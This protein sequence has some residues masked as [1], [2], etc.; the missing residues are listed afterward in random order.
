MLILAPTVVGL[1]VAA[2]WTRDA[3]AQAD[4]RPDAQEP[5]RTVLLELFTSQGCSSCPPADRLLTELAAHGVAGVDVVALSYHVDYWN[6]IG[7]TDPFSSAEWSDRQRRY[8]RQLADDR[9]YTP[10]LVIDG[11]SECVGS[12][13]REV[14]KRVAGAARRPAVGAVRADWSPQGLRLA[15]SLPDSAPGPA[16]VW[17][18]VFE[19]DLETEV[20]RGENARRTLRNDNVVRRLSTQVELAPGKSWQGLYELA[21]EPGWRQDRLGVA[22]FLQDPTTLEVHAATAE[23]L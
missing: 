20:R 18:A 3:G 4:A 14:A 7:W 12:Q 10:Q 22:V 23:R 21:P 15:A 17:V 13:R 19:T 5:R 9:V 2:W 1:L 8:A 6:Y 11:V 16:W